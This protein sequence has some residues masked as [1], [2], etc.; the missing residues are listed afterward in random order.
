MSCRSCTHFA[1]GEGDAEH[2]PHRAL[3]ATPIAGICRRYPPQ[4]ARIGD[5]PALTLFPKVH[6][7]QSCG[8][9]DSEVPV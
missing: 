4:L 7:M 5:D 1:F 2:E 6:V 8:E 3:P 9:Y